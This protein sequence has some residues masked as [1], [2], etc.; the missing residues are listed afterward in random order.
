[1]IQYNHPALVAQWIELFRPKE[2]IW[3]RFLSRAQT[4][5]MSEVTEKKVKGFTFDR[6][7]RVFGCM[8]MRQIL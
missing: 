4:N 8:L 3:V 5:K 6:K 2:E 7:R 1:M